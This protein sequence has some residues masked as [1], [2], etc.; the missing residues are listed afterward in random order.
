MPDTVKAFLKRGEKDP[1]S[2][3]GRGIGRSVKKVGWEE[4]D[5]E[6]DVGSERQTDW[7]ALR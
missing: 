7:S 1:R 4:V 6:G 5:E 2:R 3:R